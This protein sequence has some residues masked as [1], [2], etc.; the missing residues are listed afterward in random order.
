M[1]AFFFVSALFLLAVVTC[2]QFRSPLDPKPSKGLPVKP[3][4]PFPCQPYE[5]AE[6]DIPTDVN[7]VD[8]VICISCHSMCEIYF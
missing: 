3:L 1:K 7:K 4:L 6:N 2:V 5:Y 8:Y